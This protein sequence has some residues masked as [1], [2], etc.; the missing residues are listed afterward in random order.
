MKV[1]TQPGKKDQIK[2]RSHPVFAQNVPKGYPRRSTTPRSRSPLS[3]AHT[4]PSAR[5]NAPGGNRRGP[6]PFGPSSLSRH[7][8]DPG[9]TAR[10]RRRTRSDSPRVRSANSPHS[11]GGSSGDG[12]GAIR[13][14]RSSSREEGPPVSKG[15]ERILK[16]LECLLEVQRE[17]RVRQTRILSQRRTRVARE[18]AV[19]ASGV[20]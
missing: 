13:G 19:R 14:G 8:G 5:G 9:H 2:D 18:S 3:R 6:F 7:E 1:E 16:N 17:W 4:P 11:E 20:V 10:G 12:G 15:K